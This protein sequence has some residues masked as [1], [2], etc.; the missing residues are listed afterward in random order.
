MLLRRTWLMS[1]V[2]PIIIVIVINDIK[3]FEYIKHPLNSFGEAFRVL[4]SSGYQDIIILSAG[5]V[6]T[7]V[8]GIVI[9]ILR[10]SGY[11]MF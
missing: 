9:R 2:Y 5:F 1:V 6:G 7:I 3:I 4:F 11:Q 10:R 8:S